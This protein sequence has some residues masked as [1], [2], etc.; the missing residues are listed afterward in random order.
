MTRYVAALLAA[1]I[2]NATANLLIKASAMTPA[3]G[4][5]L[6]GGIAGALWSVA[7]NWVFLL[8]L[9]CFGLNL[10]A[11]QFA[12]QKLPISMAYPIMVASGY[13]IIVVVASTRMHERLSSMQW[14]GVALILAG[15]ALVSAYVKAEPMAEASSP[16]S[17]V[18]GQ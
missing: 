4:A 10:V 5:P 12:L 8:G 2:L 1:L 15:V 9:I 6:S 3:G 14:V 7:T 18:R 11:Y 17:L 16:T 13:A